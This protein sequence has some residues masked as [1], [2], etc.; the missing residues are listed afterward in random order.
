MEVLVYLEILIIMEVQA[1]LVRTTTVIATI[2]EESLGII[3]LRTTILVILVECFL[4]II[5]M[6]Q[7]LES[8]TTT[9]IM[10]RDFLALIITIAVIVVY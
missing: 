6:V 5:T 9:T 3:I 8:I 7:E 10:E 1:Y 4:V 2:M